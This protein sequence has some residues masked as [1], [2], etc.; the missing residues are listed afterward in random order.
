MILKFSMRWLGIIVTGGALVLSACSGTSTGGSKEALYHPDV[1][2]FDID[3]NYVEALADAPVKKNYFARA[4][5]S[6]ESVKPK[7][8]EKLLA[9]RETPSTANRPPTSSRKVVSSRVVS[10]PVRTP[11]PQRSIVLASPAAGGSSASGPPR[12]TSVARAG[13]APPPVTRPAPPKP[14]VIKPKTNAPLRHQIQASDTLFG[15]SRKYGKSVESLKRANGLTG[16]TIIT[17]R[18]LIIPQ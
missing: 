15:L 12:L 6:S 17:G 2:P 10:A 13:S 5:P 4:K 18:T 3:G 8:K 9:K 7:S 11:P 16:N 14:V 1:G